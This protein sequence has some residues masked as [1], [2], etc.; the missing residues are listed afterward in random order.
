MMLGIWLVNYRKENMNK[1]YENAYARPGTGDDFGEYS[2][3]YTECNNWWYSVNPDP[4]RR[5]NCICPKCGKTV[6]V[7]VP[8]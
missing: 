3:L 8:D 2:Y 1:E 7:I 6:R 4:M 5:N